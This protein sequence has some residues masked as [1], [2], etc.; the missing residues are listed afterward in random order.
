MGKVRAGA[1][2]APNKQKSAYGTGRTSKTSLTR[3]PSASVAQCLKQ[4]LRDEW[5]VRRSYM[6]PRKR[7]L[8]FESGDWAV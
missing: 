4:E 1:Y 2:G 6:R 3:R 7:E 5:R 8:T